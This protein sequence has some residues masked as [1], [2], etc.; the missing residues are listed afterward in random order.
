[1]R[2]W[3]ED[4]IESLPRQQLLGQHRECCALRGKGWGR[5]HS[6]VDYVF[7]HPYGCLFNYHQKVMKEMY[8]RGYKVSESWKIPFY[9]GK[10]LNADTSVDLTFYSYPEHNEEY[11]QECQENLYDKNIL[12]YCNKCNEGFREFYCPY[13]NG[14]GCVHCN[15][16]GMVAEPC[17]CSKHLFLI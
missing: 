11:M 1:M 5:P 3:H 14:L 15:S 8:Y 4:L 17:S 10:Q 16:H 9:R 12:I 7:K 2:L 13:C 6:T